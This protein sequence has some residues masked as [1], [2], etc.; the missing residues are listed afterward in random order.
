MKAII[1][2]IVIVA[3]MLGTYTGY[4]N[5]TLNVLPTTKMVYDG[6]HVSVMNDSGEIIFSSRIKSTVDITKFFNFS[7]LNDGIYKVEI[8]RDFE[9]ETLSL[10]VK[11][12]NVVLIPNSQKKIFK[13][14]IRTEDNQL[15]ISKIAFDSNKMKVELF[16]EDELIYSELIEND[17]K[18]LNR[19]YKLD[20]TNKGNYKAVIKTNSRKYVENFKI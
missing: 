15:I 2:S 16:F 4:A 1:K 5:E 3:V 9:I 8:S 7:L 10:D 17:E 12:S 11:S 18:I 20:E 14:V 19:V 13:P 6:D